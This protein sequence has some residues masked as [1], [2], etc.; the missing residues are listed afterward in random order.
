MHRDIKPQN[1]LISFKQHAY[2]STFPLVDGEQ[3]RKKTRRGR[4]DPNRSSD[5]QEEEEEEE[6]KRREDHDESILDSTVHFSSST[7]QEEENAPPQDGEEMQARMLRE[8]FEQQSLHSDHE[9]VK[10]ECTSSDDMP[11]AY[12]DDESPFSGSNPIK[13]SRFL[14]R[15]IMF[16]HMILK[17]CDFGLAKMVGLNR[18]HTMEVITLYYKPPEILLV[19]QDARR[20]DYNQ[21][22]DIWSMGCTLTE[23]L[24]IILLFLLLLLL[25]G[26]DVPTMITFTI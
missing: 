25:K 13:K 6:L 14:T 12:Y 2:N 8:L 26:Y 15:D 21:S 3:P 24:N 17:I 23:V 11:Y 4:E 7:M 1:I 9:E 5:C 18:E 20:A 22:V 19:P 16:R 10:Y